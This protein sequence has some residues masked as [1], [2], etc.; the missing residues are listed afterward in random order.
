MDCST[1][2]FQSLIGSGVSLSTPQLQRAHIIFLKSPPMDL[3]AIFQ[4]CALKRK[5]RVT[6][7][8]IKA[9]VSNV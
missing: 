8:G 1:F 6:F 5:M 9:V 3:S 7:G 2:H 4:R